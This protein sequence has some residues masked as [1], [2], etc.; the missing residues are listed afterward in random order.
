MSPQDLAA[1]LDARADAD[2][3][4]SMMSFGESLSAGHCAKVYREAAQLIRDHLVPS[5]TKVAPTASG[6]YWRRFY[7]GGNVELVRVTMDP[8]A[9]TG[10]ALWSAVLIPSDHEDPDEVTWPGRVSCYPNA[11]WC[12]PVDPPSP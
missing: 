12:G 7:G 3:D 11:E 5:W 8:A 4:H 6:T 2:S 9:D 1:Q 10:G